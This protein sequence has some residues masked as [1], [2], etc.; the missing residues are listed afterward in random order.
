M[1]VKY[2]AHSSD[3]RDYYMPDLSTPHGRLAYARRHLAKIESAAEAARKLRLKYATYAAHENGTRGMG[4]DEAAR[5]AKAYKIDREWLVWGTGNPRGA[6]IMDKMAQLDPER[7]MAAE[8][9]IEWLLSQQA[10]TRE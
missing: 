8:S 6:S 7:R 1:V 2:E 9:H 10:K 4:A 5:Y 3:M